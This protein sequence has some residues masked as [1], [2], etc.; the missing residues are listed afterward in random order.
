[1]TEA[2]AIAILQLHHQGNHAQQL[3]A[4]D[5][6]LHT[7]SQ[8]VKAVADELDK[9]KDSDHQDEING[10]QREVA[11][12]KEEMVKIKGE[13]ELGTEANAVADR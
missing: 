12:L 5:A 2:A 13:K 11:A 1:M 6:A 7:V 9:V 4:E 3:T 8:L 10:L